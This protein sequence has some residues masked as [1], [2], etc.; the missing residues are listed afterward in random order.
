MTQPWQPPE[1]QDLHVRPGYTDYECQ[2]CGS[3]VSNIITHNNFHYRLDKLLDAITA[4]TRV[5]VPDLPDGMLLST[6]IPV[7]VHHVD[8]DEATYAE[9]SMSWYRITC[10]KSVRK[11]SSISGVKPKYCSKECTDEAKRRN[12][13]EGSDNERSAT[14]P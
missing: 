13:R 11:Q 4:L 10:G 9:L 1:Y 2:R 6:S 7:E 5:V 14:A 3:I 8:P 12:A